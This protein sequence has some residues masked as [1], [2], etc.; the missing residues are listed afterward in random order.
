MQRE[1][2]IVQDKTAYGTGIAEAFKQGAE[3]VG[4][5]IIGFE[6]ITLGKRTL[7]VF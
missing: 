3:R 4:A 6:G 5:E 7:M 1:I 2:F